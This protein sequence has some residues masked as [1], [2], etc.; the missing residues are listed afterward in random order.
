MHQRVI[1]RSQYLP[2][3]DFLVFDCLSRWN[4]SIVVQFVGV[5]L[6]DVHVFTKGFANLCLSGVAL[7]DI[8]F[9]FIGSIKS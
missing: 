6:E 4:N 1:R 8:F 7:C 5:F 3:K 2:D 9:S